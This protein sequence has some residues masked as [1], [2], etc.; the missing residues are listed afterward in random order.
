[1]QRSAQ[2]PARP[3]PIRYPPG[4]AYLGNPGAQHPNGLAPHRCTT[5]D[6]SGAFG[7]PASA[8]DNGEHCVF[9]WRFSATALGVR[10]VPTNN[11]VG[12]CLDHAL[13][14]Y[15]SRGDG[16]PDTPWPSCASQPLHADPASHVPDAVAMGCVSS[17]TAGLGI[18]A[19]AGLPVVPAHA[20]R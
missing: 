14:R 18:A 20:K 11:T 6:A 16:F 10:D 8:T 9:A 17:T 1:M 13:L 7:T 12:L 3:R 4:E 15:S 5:Q 19:V 2:A